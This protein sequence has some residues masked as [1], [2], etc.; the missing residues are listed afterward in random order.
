MRKVL[1]FPRQ[2]VALLLVA[3]MSVLF[4]TQCKKEKNKP[5]NEEGM[6]AAFLVGK[7]WQIKA[8][9]ISPGLEEEEVQDL[10]KD[11]PA[12][13][14]DDYVIYNANGTGVEDEGPTKCDGNMPQTRTFNWNLKT[15]GTLE[16][17][18]EDD[19]TGTFKAV[20]TSATSFTITGTG[21]FG[22]DTVTR[23]IVITCNAI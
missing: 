3:F 7:K 18:V 2:R 10:Y 22:D 17:P 1:M 8:M 4:F 15:D 20:K 12:C 13:T 14:K 19:F 11:L 9:T 21:K 5:G 23:T 6:N 16:Q